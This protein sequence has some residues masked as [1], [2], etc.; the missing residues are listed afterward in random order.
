MRFYLGTHE[1]HWLRSDQFADVPLFVSAIR[2]RKKPVK[3][4]AFGSWALDSGGFSELSQHGRWTVGPE[5]YADETRRWFDRI[6]GMDWAAIQD[7]MCE[8]F[9][10]E[11]TGLTIREHQQRTVDSYLRLTAL[12][13]ELPWVPVLQGW[14][15]HDYLDCWRLYESNGVSLATSF[16]VGLGSVCRRQGT[17]EATRI[18]AALAC[19]GLRLH[20]FGFKLRGL[21][22]CANLAIS[23]DSLAWSFRARQAWCRERKRLCGFEHKGGC[24]NCADWA[25]KWRERKVLPLL[26]PKLLFA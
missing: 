1:P 2:L 18:V 14:S 5:Q 7:W 11:K 19:H 10:L 6:G 3:A 21:R 16:L 25:V 20:L 26:G 9:I 22:K 23:A 15:E 17:R 12:A 24:A 8:P 4:P 13:P